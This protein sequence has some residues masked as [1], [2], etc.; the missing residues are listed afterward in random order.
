MNSSISC[1]ENDAVQYL[2]LIWLTNN[3]LV[4]EEHKKH[5]PHDI[6]QS[7]YEG[8]FVSL[9]EPMVW[10]IEVFVFRGAGNVQ[11]LSQRWDL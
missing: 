7:W 1:P 2:A 6:S 4:V 10:K 5:C 9:A 3:E 8:V 11:N